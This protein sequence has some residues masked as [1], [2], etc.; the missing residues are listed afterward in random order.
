MEYP[1]ITG[2]NQ[3]KGLPNLR[4]W[5]MSLEAQWKMAFNEAVLRKGP[6]MSMPSPQELEYIW[7]SP[8]LRFA[9]PRAA[10]P[11]NSFELTNLSGLAHLPNVEVLVVIFHRINSN[12]AHLAKYNKLKSLYVNNCM[13]TSLDGLQDVLLL[14]ELIANMNQIEGLKP[15][16]KLTKLKKIYVNYNRL[17]SLEGI[18]KDHRKNLRDF[19]CLPNQDLLDEEIMRVENQA[20]IRCKTT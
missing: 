8:A 19:Y 18:T 9:G 4:E 10:N 15:L 11:S 7:T 13:L 3:P 5:W 2:Q 16:K 1:L 20:K 14:E 12:L 6:D 17:K